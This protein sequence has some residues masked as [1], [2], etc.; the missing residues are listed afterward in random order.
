MKGELTLGN[1][2]WKDVGTVTD[3]LCRST[4]CC[5]QLLQKELSSEVTVLLLQPG[6][7]SVK[8][9]WATQAVGTASSRWRSRVLDWLCQQVYLFQ[10]GS[11]LPSKSFLQHKIILLP[12][13]HLTFGSYEEWN[14]DSL[15]FRLLQRPCLLQNHQLSTWDSCSA[16]YFKTFWP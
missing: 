1:I 6:K 9:Q 15:K 11:L 16:E 7:Q 8:W 14:G 3:K 10:E 13:F 4:F 12:V 2:H 5:Y